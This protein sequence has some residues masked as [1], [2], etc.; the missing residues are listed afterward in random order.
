MNDGPEIRNHLFLFPEGVV[1]T[2]PVLD[3]EFHRHHA[4]QIVVSPEPFLVSFTAGQVREHAILIASDVEHRLRGECPEQTL[5]LLDRESTL[6]DLLAQKFSGTD[7]ADYQA[8]RVSRESIPVFAD[9]GSPRLSP[10]KVRAD[11]DTELCGQ[12]RRLIERIFRRVF[13]VAVGTDPPSD[14]DARIVRACE[15]I[16]ADEDFKVSL[17][18]VALHIGLSEGR[19]THLFKQVVG[20]P[21][22]RYILWQRVRRAIAVAFTEGSS[23]TDAAHAAGFADQAHFTRTFKDMFGALPGAALSMKSDTRVHVCSD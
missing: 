20:V 17:S 1:L 6:A 21:L 12:A 4:L 16:R 22:R 14:R 15:F 5:I 13:D 7:A 2:G 10:S 9:P 19:L 23:L 18:D 8:P 3:N 11:S